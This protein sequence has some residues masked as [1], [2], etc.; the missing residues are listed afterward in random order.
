MISLWWEWIFFF[1][2]TWNIAN[3]C[4]LHNQNEFFVSSFNSMTRT[5]LSSFSS[6]LVPVVLATTSVKS[7][8]DSTWMW[9]CSICLSMLCYFIWHRVLWLICA[10]AQGRISSFL[11]AEWLFFSPSHFLKKPTHLIFF[12]CPPLADILSRYCKESCNKR[13]VISMLLLISCPLS[14]SPVVGFL[15]HTVILFLV[16]EVPLYCFPQ[17][18]GSLLVPS[19]VY[20][21]FSSLYVLTDTCSLSS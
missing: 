7:F 9:L 4:E 2:K 5:N 1:L 17:W 6:S 10:I 14:I 3:Y 21:F 18:L 19:T 15:C 20:L 11:M 13:A 16:L 8:S 12:T